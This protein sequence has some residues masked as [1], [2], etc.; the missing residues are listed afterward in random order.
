MQHRQQ[1]QPKQRKED[2]QPFGTAD[3]LFVLKAHLDLS[4]FSPQAADCQQ[5]E[6][7]RYHRNRHGK[8]ACRIHPVKA[9][10]V[11][12]LRI[13]HRRQHTADVG[14]NRLQ[15]HHPC[16]PLYLIGQL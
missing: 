10:Q 9:A 1:T 12:I 11:Q 13:A 6:A 3:D 2:R 15:G 14:G 7:Q 4:V 8:E 5:A 16:Q